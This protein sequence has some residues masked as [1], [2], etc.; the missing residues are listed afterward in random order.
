MALKTFGSRTF[1]ALTFGALTLHGISSAP[2]PPPQPIVY[3]QS[4][5]PGG[6][7]KWYEEAHAK[8]VADAKRKAIEVA[9]NAD[10]ETIILTILAEAVTQYYT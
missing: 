4:G 2:V 3:Q 1:T 10:E 8:D 6:G 5:G 7:G 9:E